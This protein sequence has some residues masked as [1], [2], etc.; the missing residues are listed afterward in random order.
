V[1]PS[2]Y[3]NSATN[4]VIEIFGAGLTN[5]PNLKLA[6]LNKSQSQTN[7][8]STENDTMDKQARVALCKS[9]GLADEAADAS[10]LAAAESLKT[11]KA[12]ALNK[13]LTPDA[14]KFIPIADYQLVKGDLDK[15]LN[16]IQEQATQSAE[17]VIDAAIAAGKIAPA[18]KDYHLN[19]CKSP[20]VLANFKK[21]VEASPSINGDGK[22]VDGDGDDKSKALNSQQRKILE[23]LGVDPEDKDVAADLKTQT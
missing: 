12:T 15:A 17:V 2:I 6:A 5:R 20:E 11:D 16:S 8:T 4:A 19:S 22:D 13:A 21:M 23:G 7:E 3:Y 18:S 14:T 9:L 1:S 10:I